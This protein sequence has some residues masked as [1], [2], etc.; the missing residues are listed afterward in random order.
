[1]RNRQGSP[2]IG[3]LS[4]AAPRDQV[5]RGQ[6]PLFGVDGA[7]YDRHRRHGPEVMRIEDVEHRLGD[8]GKVVVELVANVRVQECD[9]L[10][11]PCHHRIVGL[12]G[13]E[14]Q[15]AGNLRVLAGELDALLSKVGELP[16]VVAQEGIAH[17]PPSWRMNRPEPAAND[18]RTRTG[19][20]SRPTV[21]LASITSLRGSRG[22]IPGSTLTFTS[23]RRG[24]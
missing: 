14:P 1:M 4:T 6:A 5:S 19:S 9:R 7:L 16:H 3:S 22:V 15:P 24:S 12:V 10:D 11:Q 2:S 17:L 23:L 21:S 20:V 18:A 13:T 8:L